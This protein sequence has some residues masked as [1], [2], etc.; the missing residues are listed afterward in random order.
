VH[1]KAEFLKMAKEGDRG[2]LDIEPPP[3]SVR[4]YWRW[5]IAAYDM[6][7]GLVISKSV[8]GLISWT[9]PSPFATS[10]L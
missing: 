3:C 6:K 1:S 2:L 9:C 7:S 5:G 10:P 4:Q 8:G